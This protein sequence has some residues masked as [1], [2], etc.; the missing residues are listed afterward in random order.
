MNPSLIPKILCVAWWTISYI[1]SIPKWI[2]YLKNVSGSSDP[3]TEMREKSSWINVST[4]FFIK[5]FGMCYYDLAYPHDALLFMITYLWT[6]YLR[7]YFCFCL[8]LDQNFVRSHFSD[9][10][11]GSNLQALPKNFLKFSLKT[12]FIFRSVSTKSTWFALCVFTVFSLFV[13]TKSPHQ[14]IIGGILV[15]YVVDIHDM[16]VLLFLCRSR[17]RHKRKFKHYLFES[18]LKLWFWYWFSRI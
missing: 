8:E 11:E 12:I 3:E 10:R 17:Y 2:R 14:E 5:L 7:F 18:I 15:F 1:S 13:S 6:Q 9:Q 4:A 16:N